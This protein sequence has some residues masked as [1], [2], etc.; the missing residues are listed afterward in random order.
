M[1]KFLE[2]FG[3]AGV[4]ITK[5]ARSGLIN[6]TSSWTAERQHYHLYDYGLR[7]RFPI[8]RFPSGSC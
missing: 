1:A 4:T 2:G 8:M 3:E 5:S 6:A 7:D